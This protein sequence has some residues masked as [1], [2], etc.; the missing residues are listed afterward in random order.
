MSSNIKALLFEQVN[1]ISKMIIKPAINEEDKQ[2]D[3]FI[4]NSKKF[5]I[6]ELINK[7]K[8]KEHV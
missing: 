6:S 1:I 5:D 4:V 7:V 8:E 2:T 3:K